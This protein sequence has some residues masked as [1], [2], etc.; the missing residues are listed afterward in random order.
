MFWLFNKTGIM[1]V[2][3][4]LLLVLA[5]YLVRANG[6]WPDAYRY[7]PAVSSDRR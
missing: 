2:V 5:I 4:V 7:E 6:S 1:T 3:G